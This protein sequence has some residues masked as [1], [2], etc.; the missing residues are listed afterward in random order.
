MGRYQS[1]SRS[2]TVL[3]D[4]CLV[5]IRLGTIES[6]DCARSCSSRSAK[7]LADPC[8]EQTPLVAI[9]RIKKPFH[10]FDTHSSED[11]L[12]QHNSCTLNQR[13]LSGRVE[14]H[15]S[16]PALAVDHAAV[17]T[18]V[19]TL[20][21]LNCS[22]QEGHAMDAR[23]HSVVQMMER[24][25]SRRVQLNE[26]ASSIRTSP[27]GLRLLFRKHV[28]VPPAR[29][30]KRLRLERARLL[31]STT[32][33]SVKEVSHAVGCTDVS[34]FVR[35]FER[36]YGLSPTRFRVKRPGIVGGH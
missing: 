33:L 16:R 9:C 36:A 26:L 11:A 23:V 31:L 17:P 15:G 24:D 3:L 5:G 28:G 12:T 35:D 10:I 2:D 29:Y 22:H 21:R 7:N 19:H 4:R 18:I 14:P 34:H 27:S 8:H 25:L 1:V 20:L 32:Q 30:M 13:I 6:A